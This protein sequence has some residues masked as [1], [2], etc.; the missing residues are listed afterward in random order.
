MPVA[1]LW[2]ILPKVQDDGEVTL[3]FEEIQK[4]CG[5]AQVLLGNAIMWNELLYDQME[6]ETCG[7]DEIRKISET[8]DKLYLEI[9]EGEQLFFIRE[10][11]ADV[12]YQYLEK[13]QYLN[14]PERTLERMQ[15]E[16]KVFRD[17]RMG[18][19]ELR[20]YVQELRENR[21]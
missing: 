4:K 21:D 17:I 1:E 18:C 19:S 16:K 9:M 15:L 8:Y 14:T 5:E 7:R 11:C 10:Y 6:K 3:F 13:A 2:K 12:L 20:S